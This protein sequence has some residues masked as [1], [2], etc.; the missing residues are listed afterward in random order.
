MFWPYVLTRQTIMASLCH[1]FRG[2]AREVQLL[3]T[4]LLALRDPQCALH[5]LASAI[6]PHEVQ[7]I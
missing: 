5:D 2:I 6:L 4:L 7:N 3:L 1:L